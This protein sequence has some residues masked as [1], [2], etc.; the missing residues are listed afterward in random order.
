MQDV[1]TRAQ[2][3]LATVSFVLNRSKPI[4]EAT[5]T[6]VEEA[7]LELGYQRNPIGTAL[8]RGRTRILAML[9]PALRR[10]LCIA[11]ADFFTGA[12]IRA[13][14]RGYSLVLW[15]VENSTGD[16]VTL[17]STGL[18]DGVVLMEVQLDDARVA[19]L[20]QGT[21]PFA[22]IGRTHDASSLLYADVDF[23]SSVTEALS[24]LIARGHT[25]FA[26]VER[27]SVDGVPDHGGVVRARRSFEQ[28]VERRG[29]SGVVLDCAESSTAGRELGAT[30]TAR[31]PD[32]TALLVINESAAPGIVA[33]LH[34]A[35]TRVP[36]DVSVIAVG[37]TPDTA[38]M[39]DPPLTFMRIPGQELGR[40]GVD[41]VI[42][43]IERSEQP[44]GPTLLPCELVPGATVA[45]APPGR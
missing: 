12:A 20:E 31:H 36:H 38:A 11:A 19:A 25:R 22:L 35:G 43:R 27:E 41:L 10:R 45:N 30:L 16:A 37:A 2:V 29:L 24:A 6:R 39:T 21:T 5:R 9:Y 15:P 44:P 32:V 23:E 13:R 40:L 3:S 33:G 4:S 7:M 17:M 1:A 26:L 28:T 42:G 18:V 14:E 34:H 8:A